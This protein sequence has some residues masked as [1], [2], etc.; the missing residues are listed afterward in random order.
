M[1]KIICILMLFLLMTTCACSYST[2]Q[3][4][5]KT[6]AKEY[7]AEYISN[8]EGDNLTGA[9]EIIIEKIINID[10]MYWLIS[11]TATIVTKENSSLTQLRFSFI[12]TKN[13]DDQYTFSHIEV[14]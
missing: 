14:Y 6:E 1:K 11:G 9:P 3:D 5:L 12:A 4:P 13:T 7:I 2:T 8:N 10:T